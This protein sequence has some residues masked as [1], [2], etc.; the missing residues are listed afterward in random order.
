M[1]EKKKSDQKSLINIIYY[2][3]KLYRELVFGYNAII[4]FQMRSRSNAK[5]ELTVNHCLYFVI[6]AASLNAEA[7]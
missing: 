6:E 5:S 4:L 3:R 1:L 2:K 7:A